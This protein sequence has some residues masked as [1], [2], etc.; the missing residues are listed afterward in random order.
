METF[1]SNPEF[2]NPA[3]QETRGE[4][5]VSKTQPAW[6]RAER[7]GFKKLLGMVL[8][9]RGCEGLGENCQITLYLTVRKT[10]QRVL[11]SR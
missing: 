10:V 4:E 8:G 1:L 7:E 3:N 9:E 2:L 6:I 11:Q 5:R